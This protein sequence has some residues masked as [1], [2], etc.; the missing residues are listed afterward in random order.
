MSEEPRSEV[1]GR[2]ACGD[3]TG[4]CFFEEKNGWYARG[5]SDIP[6]AGFKL[7]A[8]HSSIREL[9]LA[10]ELEHLDFCPAYVC[11]HCN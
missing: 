9:C 1:D 5:H 11:L 10:F 8:I 4:L 2:V 6:F 7:C 3:S